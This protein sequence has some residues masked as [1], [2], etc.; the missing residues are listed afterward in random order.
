VSEQGKKYDNG[1]PAMGLIPPLALEAEA[2]VWSFGQGK[3]DAFNWTK[4]IKYT[5]ILGAMLRH[6]TAIM[7]GEDVDA[8]SGQLHAAHVRCCAAMLIEFSMTHRDDLDDRIY[9]KIGKE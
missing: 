9:S 3:Y 6:T 5:R 8:E 7:R 2:L 4:G 1:K